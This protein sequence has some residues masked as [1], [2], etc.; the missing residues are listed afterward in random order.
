MAHVLKRSLPAEQGHHRAIP[1]NIGAWKG[2]E[3]DCDRPS[4]IAAI[5]AQDIIFRSYRNGADSIVLYVAFYKDVDSADNMHAPDVCYEGQGWLVA[6]DEVV[7][8]NLGAAR[9]L[10]NR[11]VVTKAGKKELVYT[12]WLTS[13][14]TI[15][16]NSLNRFYQMYM[17]VTGR[18]ASTIWIRMSRR[19]GENPAREEERMARFCADLM[20]ILHGRAG[21]G[22]RMTGVSKRF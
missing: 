9:A 22:D 5:G 14:R 4:L 8:K 16:R 13:G 3:V 11:L 20:P 19:L 7:G 1:V 21:T 10:I 15:P 17:S 2:S 12:W 18:S 6:E